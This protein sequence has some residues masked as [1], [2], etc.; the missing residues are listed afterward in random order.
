MKPARREARARR[1]LRRAAARREGAGRGPLAGRAWRRLVAAA[2]AG[3]PE[4]QDAIRA[5]AAELPPRDARDLLAAAPREDTERAAY[6][7][8]IGQHERRRALDPGNGLLALAH[9]GA[10][11]DTRRRLRAALADTGDF[12]A[13]HAVITGDSRDRIAELPTAELGHLARRLARHGRWRELRALAF[14]LPLV[15]AAAVAALL[16]PEHRGGERGHVLERLA[17]AGLSG[18]LGDVVRQLEGRA[19]TE[20]W[21]PRDT[22]WWVTGSFSPDGT[23][24]ALAA[25]TYPRPP[26]LKLVEVH[27]V[28]LASGRTETRFSEHVPNDA[29]VEGVVHLGGEVLLQLVGAEPGERHTTVVRTAA[30]PPVRHALRDRISGLR[31]SADGGA[32][33][34]STDGVLV[35]VRPGTDRPRPGPGA[36]FGHGSDGLPYDGM[37]AAVTGTATFPAHGLFAAVQHGRAVVADEDGLVV[38]EFALGT[39]GTEGPLRSSPAVTFVSP[40]R[41]AVCHLGKGPDGGPALHTEIWDFAGRPRRVDAHDGRPLDKWPLDFWQGLPLDGVFAGRLFCDDTATRLH[42]DAPL[43]VGASAGAPSADVRR[44]VALSPRHDALAVQAVSDRGGDHTMRVELYAPHPP[45]AR[46]LMRL[47]LLHATPRDLDE[48]RRV[49]ARMYDPAVRDALALLEYCLTER[50]GGG[51]GSGDESPTADGPRDTAV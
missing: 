3:R 6:L 12:V 45:A 37:T 38:A 36:P 21:R 2:G 39:G 47:P 30:G 4:A 11:E 16:P 27:T 31:R 50:L 20:L 9:R 8:L 35:F 24:L 41:I 44:F 14:D 34:L 15:H 10:D 7:A 48:A 26:E 49:R 43:L 19:Y 18:Y 46:E 5:V 32:L 13:L 28:D 40:T 23:E 17:F 42:R 25:H 22:A 51:T 33:G 29:T 1:L